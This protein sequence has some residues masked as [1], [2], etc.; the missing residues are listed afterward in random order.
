M[1]QYKRHLTFYKRKETESHQ[2]R[3]LAGKEADTKTV[4]PMAGRKAAVY[5][6]A[7]VNGR[8]P[9]GLASPSLAGSNFP[10]TL[11]QTVEVLDIGKGEKGAE[12]CSS[13]Y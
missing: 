5:N 3:C 13:L 10:S 9:V 12:K 11:L 4:V 8:G 6:G 7:A 1:P 2:I